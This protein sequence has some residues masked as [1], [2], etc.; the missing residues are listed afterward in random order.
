[1]KTLLH[2]AK[3]APSAEFFKG[4]RA[5]YRWKGRLDSVDDPT[6]LTQLIVSIIQ[7]GYSDGID[8]LLSYAIEGET[9]YGRF[10]D[11]NETFGYT[12]KDDEITFWPLGN[13]A[14][15]D[16]LYATWRRDA[17]IPKKKKNCTK[18][19]AC[20][21]GCISSNKK[22]KVKP[23]PKGQQN[24]AEAKAILKEGATTPVKGKAKVKRPKPRASTEG[25]NIDPFSPENN[26]NFPKEGESNPK[27]GRG[28]KAKA[29]KKEQSPIEKKT[30]KQP[31]K[32][33][34]KQPESKKPPYKPLMS[35]EDAL[36]YTKDS[37]YQFTVYHGSTE[38]GAK[39]ITEDGVDV[40]KNGTAV[41]GQGFYTAVDPAAARAYADSAR[42][43]DPGG[44]VAMRVDVRNPK[45][46]ETRL[47]WMEYQ[48]SIGLDPYDISLNNSIKVTAK[49]KELGFDA[50]E[51]KEH[52]YICVFDPKQVAAFDV[53][54]LAGGD[55]SDDF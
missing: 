49:L 17:T 37:V 6:R 36:E 4:Y 40:S 9:I 41:Y 55:Y 45:I 13:L 48:S 27:T 11:S 28:S 30:Q 18:G 42:D 31:E 32:D 29:K 24:I 51:V 2:V 16:S 50:V 12:I 10:Q 43:G 34:P 35:E 33:E 52:G 19:R 47:E 38:G 5:A 21:N 53:E 8:A 44:I 39:A 26:A 7:E 20:G 14:R 46:V 3:T 25:Q 54:R 15:S 1:M 22:C 23:S